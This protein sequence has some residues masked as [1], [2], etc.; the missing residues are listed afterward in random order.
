LLPIAATLHAPVGNCL[1]IRRKTLN[2]SI[3]PEPLRSVS[4]SAI[5][6]QNIKSIDSV[7]TLFVTFDTEPQESE[8][9]RGATHASFESSPLGALPYGQMTDNNKNILMNNH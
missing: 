1:A 3:G 6:T 2:I 9:E 5:Q 8:F 4:S 7:K